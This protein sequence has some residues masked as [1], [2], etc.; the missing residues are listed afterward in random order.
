MTYLSMK[1]NLHHLMPHL[2]QKMFGHKP[3]CLNSIEDLMLQKNLKEGWVFLFGIELSIPYGINQG[4][5]ETYG[6]VSPTR[7]EGQKIRARRQ[8]F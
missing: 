6:F 5:V 7:H 8:G 3:W 4:A 2:W 1:H